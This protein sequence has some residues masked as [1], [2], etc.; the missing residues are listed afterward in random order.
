MNTETLKDRNTERQKNRQSERQKT[1]MHI[2][3]YRDRK[4]EKA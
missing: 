4:T 1:E 2:E 3:I